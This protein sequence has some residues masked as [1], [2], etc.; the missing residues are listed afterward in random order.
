MLSYLAHAEAFD[1]GI[2]HRDISAGNMLLY[3]DQK[4]AWC[5]LLND[6]ELSK[7]IDFSSLEGR[8]P[9]RTVSLVIC[10]RRAF[11][12]CAD[13]EGTGYMAVHVGECSEQPLSKNR[14]PGRAR[15]VFPR[16]DLLRSPIPPSQS[17]R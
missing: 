7:K 14:H 17:R 5:G 13:E 11:W 9:D 8:Q 4:G 10:S 3:K 6:W 16:L 1:A 15:V 12:Q 2:I